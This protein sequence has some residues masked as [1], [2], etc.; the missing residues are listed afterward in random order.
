MPRWEIWMNGYSDESQFQGDALPKLIG[1]EEAPDYD[2]ACELVAAEW[3]KTAPFGHKMVRKKRMDLTG[4]PFG[5]H[6]AWSIW[7]IR[8]L[9]DK[10]AVEE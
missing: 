2:S 6:D 3:N 4:R 5:D 7:A 9:C 1:V 10:V 8:V